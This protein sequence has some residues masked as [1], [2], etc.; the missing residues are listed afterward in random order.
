MSTFKVAGFFCNTFFFGG[1]VSDSACLGLWSLVFSGMCCVCGA[2]CDT[3]SRRCSRRFSVKGPLGHVCLHP[4]LISVAFVGCFSDVARSVPCALHHTAPGQFQLVFQN[5][6]F[7]FFPPRIFGT[8]VPSDA[9]VGL[10]IGYLGLLPVFYDR[11]VTISTCCRLQPLWIFG[12]VFF[13]QRKR[14]SQFEFL[15]FIASEIILD[16]FFPYSISGSRLVFLAHD[17]FVVPGFP[18]SCA[19]RCFLFLCGII[20]HPRVALPFS[21]PGWSYAFVSPVSSTHLNKG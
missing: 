5:S 6:S 1:E 2:D 18:L 9:T 13:T 17:S 11:V 14:K 4:F 16:W 15:S 7:F 19:S 10:P 3:H 20:G 12:H 21:L 8:P